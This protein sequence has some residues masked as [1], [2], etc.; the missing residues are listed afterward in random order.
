MESV[1]FFIIGIVVLRDE[2][3]RKVKVREH[4][5]HWNLR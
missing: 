1:V 3:A 4:N 2:N 5:R